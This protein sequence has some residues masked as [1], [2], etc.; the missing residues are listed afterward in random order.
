M[1]AGKQDFRNFLLFLL[2]TKEASLIGNYSL[3]PQGHT[4]IIRI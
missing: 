3:N 4:D 1:W 2:N